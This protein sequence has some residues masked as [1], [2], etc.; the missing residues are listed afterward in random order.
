MKSI[1]NVTELLQ[2]LTSPEGSKV[3]YAMG[4]EI[5]KTFRQEIKSLVDDN[6]LKFTYKL[7]TIV[8][9]PILF[10]VLIDSHGWH[11]RRGS[12]CKTPRGDPEKIA[13]R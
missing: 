4:V 6:Q 12:A 11:R 3:A 10:A 1:N 8:G 5:G 2:I 13:W 7:G 9:P